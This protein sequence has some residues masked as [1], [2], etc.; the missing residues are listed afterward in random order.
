MSSWV[1]LNGTFQNRVRPCAL[2]RLV[3][4]PR[5]PSW[6]TQA[7]VKTEFPPAN[8][9][10]TISHTQLQSHWA[11]GYLGSALLTI[12][13]VYLTAGVVCLWSF[14]DVVC[15]NVPAEPV[16]RCKRNKHR[17]MKYTL[18]P[19]VYT[20]TVLCTPTELTEIQSFGPTPSQDLVKIT[21]Y[22]QQNCSISLKP[23]RR[24]KKK[25]LFVSC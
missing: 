6:F 11:E 9:A 25:S 8:Q 24:R 21:A 17:S 23:T 14:R 10:D 1:S 22:L 19:P 13:K 7:L 15:Q 5:G 4:E 18:R 2:F 12:N 3:W 20:V 16:H